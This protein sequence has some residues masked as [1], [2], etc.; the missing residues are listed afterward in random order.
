MITKSGVP[1]FSPDE[2]TDELLYHYT[3][4]GGL[5]S[6]LKNMR[7]RLSSFSS[8]VD[9]PVDGEMVGRMYQKT[10]QDTKKDVERKISEYRF[11][12]MVPDNN[13]IF[14]GSENSLVWY[15]YSKEYNGACI[16]FNK[17]KLEERFKSDHWDVDIV[18]VKYDDFPPD[19]KGLSVLDMEFDSNKRNDIFAWKQKCWNGQNETRLLCHKK[20]LNTDDCYIDITG[21]IDHI[22]LGYKFK[23]FKDLFSSVYGKSSK[24]RGKFCSLSFSE[25][26]FEQGVMI[27]GVSVR[28]GRFLEERPMFKKADEEIKKKS[29]SNNNQ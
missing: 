15:M 28:Y 20:G 21:T 3:H 19:L 13:P 12:S 29:E 8:G 6:I 1:V 4:A 27:D 11:I 7:F 14:N 5:F 25:T 9:D 24:A 23:R 26:L 22:S 10:H 17:K 18:N 16:A 2:T